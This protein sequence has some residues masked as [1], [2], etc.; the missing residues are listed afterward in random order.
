[1]T[2][3]KQNADITTL[4]AENLTQARE[5]TGLTQKQ[6]SDL[7]GIYQSDISRIERGLANPSLITLKRLADGMGLQVQIDFVKSVA[8]KEDI[9][10]WANESVFYQIYPLGFC[11]APF[12]ND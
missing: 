12:E 2:C 1:M 9:T 7:T 10:M 4:L 5:S 6:L 3:K 11:N 8:N